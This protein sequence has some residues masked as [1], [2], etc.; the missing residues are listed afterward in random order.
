[1]R[2]A[3]SSC[4]CVDARI[5]G[6]RR[7]GG[8]GVFPH[9]LDRYKPG[10]IAVTRKGE[11]FCN[12]SESYHD[13]GAAMIRACEGEAETAAWL[14]CDHRAIRKYGLGHAKPAPFPIQL[15]IANGYIQRGATLGDLANE[16]GIDAEGLINTVETYNLHSE[17]GEDPAFGRGTTSFNRY[18][19]DPA[20]GPNPCVAPI[21]QGH[22][23]R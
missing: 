9:L 4:G 5:A 6:S 23:T 1:M 3:L 19:A 16:T 7:D 15:A 14:I 8:H 10:I 17:R 12:E 21:R 20:H 18:L 22:S 13:V 11:R 2:I